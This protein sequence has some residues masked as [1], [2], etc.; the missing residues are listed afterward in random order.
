MQ[1][2]RKIYFDKGT[3]V[4]IQITS[5]RAGSIVEFTEDQDFEMYARLAER[6]KE[7]VDV[8]ALEYGDY[9][10]D[11]IEGRLTGVNPT[12]KELLFSY[13]DPQAPGE[14]TPPQPALS[15]EVAALK[16]RQE[17]SEAAI[18]MLMDFGMM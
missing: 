9:A 4:V 17:A 15:V 12:T 7:T 6:V 8:I 10:Q 13:P 2:G 18:L 3:G 16:E 14:V 1:I 5:E 11:F